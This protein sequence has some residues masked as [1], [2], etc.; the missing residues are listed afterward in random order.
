MPKAAKLGKMTIVG[1][2]LIGVAAGGMAGASAAGLMS[3]G[4]GKPEFP[5]NSKGLTYGSS[6]HSRSPADDPSLVLVVATNGKEGYS[7][8]TDLNTPD[9]ASIDQSQEWQKSHTGP[10]AIPVYDS[11]GAQRIGTFMIGKQ[12]GEDAAVSATGTVDTR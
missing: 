12:A 10:R 7:Y 2:V 8:A 4:G 6:L 9:F 5:H 11:E 3:S 1:A